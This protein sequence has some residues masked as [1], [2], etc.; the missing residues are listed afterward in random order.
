MTIDFLLSS[1]R[2]NANREAIIWEGR[3]YSYR[4][5][6]E[7]LGYWQTII[8]ENSVTEGTVVILEADFSPNAVALFL[9]LIESGCILVPL[10][11]AAGAKRDEFIEVAEG[12]V[13][14]TLDHQDNLSI[15]K[16][17]RRASHEL[18]AR[19][20]SLGHPGLVLFSS[21]STGKSKAGVHDMMPLMDK[22]K[23]PRHRL[24]TIS[25]LL[26]D[27]IGGINTMLYTL[28]NGGCLV[29][30]PDRSPDSVLRAVE[31][32]RVQLL[33]TS[34]TFINLVLLS[35]AYKHYK[36]DSLETVTYGTEPMPASTLQRFHQLFPN[37]R[38]V[39]TYGL[40]EVGIL[41]S[42][43]K[44]SDSLWVKVG[45]E[46]FRTRVIDGILHI[47]AQSAMLGYLNAPSPF[48]DDGWMNTGDQVEVDGEYV[49][50]LGRQSEIINVGGEKVYPAEVESVIQ[51][52]DNVAEVTVFGEKNPIT[53]N[54]VCAKVTMARN[55][56]YGSFTKRLKSFC[57]Q[58]LQ[59]Y[60]VPI[61]VIIAEERQYSDRFKKVRAG[62]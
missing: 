46:E 62:Q 45:G 43:S 38:L 34:P 44:S 19:L 39:Q 35:E 8:R 53:G 29:T 41:R 5:L 56:D 4:L 18:Y 60:K 25:F 11:F 21:G 10:T 24:R 7:R 59:D 36:L 3:S 20:R 32:H 42:K 1:F 13:C 22:F 61:K 26:Y 14:L 58:R 55:E 51:E 2:A 17:D 49:R 23:V 6:L 9:A 30:V 50:F 15:Q 52:L 54:I 48:S 16:R 31:A 40:S 47:K 28:S 33:P 57:H 27:H 12:E 37:I